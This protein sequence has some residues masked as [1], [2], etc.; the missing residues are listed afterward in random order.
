[1]KVIFDQNKHLLFLFYLITNC[2]ISIYVFSNGFLL[3]RLALNATNY[4]THENLKQFNKAII[5]FVDALRFDFAFTNKNSSINGLKTIEKLLQFEPSHAKLFKFIADVYKA[6]LFSFFFKIINF[7][8]PPTTTM[9]RIKGL[10]SGTLPTFI[11]AGA[12]F[13]SYLIEED[14]LIKQFSINNRSIV[15][16]GDDTWMSLFEKSLFE[17]TFPYPSFNVKDVDT[18]DTNVNEKLISILN[19]EFNIKWELIIAH[20]LGIHCAT[21]ICW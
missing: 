20:Y 10:M 21:H 8:K 12:N 17:K 3:R 13:N 9:Q 6:V 5:L 16:M 11:D 4:E 15:F 1:M 7:L 14:N 2:F 18:V 19:Y